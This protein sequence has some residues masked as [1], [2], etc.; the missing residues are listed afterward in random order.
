VEVERE[1]QDFCLP[2]QKGK[3]CDEVKE[4]QKEKL[5]RVLAY[6]NSHLLGV[7]DENR[8]DL[9]EDFFKNLIG[10]GADIIPVDPN[11]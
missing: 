5:R 2:I 9:D 11:Q 1:G 4:D 6:I 3:V 7:G 8:I 10:F